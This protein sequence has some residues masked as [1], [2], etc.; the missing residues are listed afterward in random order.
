MLDA[1][2]I[3][4]KLMPRHLEHDQRPH[5][6]HYSCLSA[7]VRDYEEMRKN[8]SLEESGDFYIQLCCNDKIISQRYLTRSDYDAVIQQVDISA[9]HAA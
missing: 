9:M 2:N 5:H 3:H 1:N 4:I 8:S 7:A 6:M